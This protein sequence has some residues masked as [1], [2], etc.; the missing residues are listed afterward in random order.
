MMPQEERKENRTYPR[1][2]FHSQIRYQLR[3][4]QDFDNAVSNDISSGGLRF[5][6]HRFIP[7][8]TLVMLE[9]NVANRLLRPIAKVAW[10]N[11]LAHTDRNQMGVEF[12]EFNELERNYL[13]DF[14][15]MQLG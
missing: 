12:V 9:I 8:S 13:K 5:T 2:D 10:A 3:G 7:T 15:T 14:I 11:Q 4:R 6:N 1:I